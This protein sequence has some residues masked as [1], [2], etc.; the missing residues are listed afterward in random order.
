MSIS[1]HKMKLD[2]ELL[3]IQVTFQIE[4]KKINKRI[5]LTGL[6]LSGN[7]RSKTTI[8]LKSI[9]PSNVKHLLKNTVYINQE[10]KKDNENQIAKVKELEKIYSFKIDAL[11]NLKKE[12]SSGNFENIYFEKFKE[13]K[14]Y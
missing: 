14:I 3:N 5:Y 7:E 12:N 2:K 13:E 1:G 10:I 11:N 8:F 6:Y 4:P 9:I